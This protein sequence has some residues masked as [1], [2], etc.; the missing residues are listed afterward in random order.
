MRMTFNKYLLLVVVLVLNTF[1][2]LQAYELVSTKTEQSAT[3]D[4]SVSQ[5]SANNSNNQ[6]ITL[7]SFNPFHK[8]T[9]GKLLFDLIESNNV[10]N[11]EATIKNKS[12]NKNDL[13]TAFINAQLHEHS[14][15]ELQ[16]NIYRP[17]SD[18]NE[19]TLRLHIQFQVFII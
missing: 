14:S 11:E 2:S 19:P 6:C 3:H 15:K 7:A 16:K 1:A 9:E 10:E 13:V 18:I 12:Y 5:V 17:Q 8:E 4:L